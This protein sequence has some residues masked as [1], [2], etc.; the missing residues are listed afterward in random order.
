VRGK[1]KATFQES[2][3]L[4][5]SDITVFEKELEEATIDSPLLC[6]SSIN[7]LK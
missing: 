1:K 5:Y 4:S 7:L 6:V 2:L 3:P